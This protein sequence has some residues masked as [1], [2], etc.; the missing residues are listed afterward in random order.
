[1][2]ARRANQ[3]NE[4]CVLRLNTIVA[5]IFYSVQQFSKLQYFSAELRLGRVIIPHQS[6]LALSQFRSSSVLFTFPLYSSLRATAGILQRWSRPT[7]SCSY[8]FL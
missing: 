5:V 3:R 2:D 4:R 8:L 7:W 6:G 1:M